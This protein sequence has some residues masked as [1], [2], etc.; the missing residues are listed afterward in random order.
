MGLMSVQVAQGQ[1]ASSAQVLQLDRGSAALVNNQCQ[2]AAISTQ[3]GF[4]LLLRE[5]G[6]RRPLGP[7]A[8][9]ACQQADQQEQRREAGQSS[10]REL[11]SRGRELRGGVR[12]GSCGRPLA[13]RPRSGWLL[14]GA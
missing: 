2:F 3:C 13:E 11:L 5:Q 12:A 8:A 9:T 6:S 7:A 4:L 1:T 14:L 10:K